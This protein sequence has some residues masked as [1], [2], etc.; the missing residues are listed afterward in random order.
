M[1][2]IAS[3]VDRFPTVEQ[4][5][6]MG[7]ARLDEEDAPAAISGPARGLPDATGGPGAVDARVIG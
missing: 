7:R 6:Q 3:H 1:D 5:K 2:S 4:G